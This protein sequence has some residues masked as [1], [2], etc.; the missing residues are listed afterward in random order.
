VDNILK[1]VIGAVFLRFIVLPFTLKTDKYFCIMRSLYKTLNKRIRSIVVELAQDPAKTY[2]EEI[3]SIDKAGHKIRKY[4]EPILFIIPVVIQALS[5][6]Y[7]LLHTHYLHRRTGW[8]THFLWFTDISAK[9]PF[10]LLPLIFLALLIVRHMTF[11]P[12]KMKFVL[13]L[14][15]LIL[16]FVSINRAAA[17]NLFGICLLFLSAVQ[18]AI[19]RLRYKSSSI[20]ELL[21]KL[22]SA[23]P[24][25]GAAESSS[26]GE[27]QSASGAGNFDLQEWLRD[28][29]E[30]ASIF[31]YDEVLMSLLLG[32]GGIVQ[33]LLYWAY[34]RWR[35]NR[36]WQADLSLRPS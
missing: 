24:D 7:L 11:I 3:S 35:R 31:L 32:I 8:Q 5:Y 28:F 27:Y 26:T 15:A 22:S 16:F 6:F 10:F 12:H 23:K 30:K 17:F 29:K 33:Y 1:P 36:E 4:R 34:F 18:S 13:V 14:P 9:D 2:M 21:S 25:S 20:A 19:M